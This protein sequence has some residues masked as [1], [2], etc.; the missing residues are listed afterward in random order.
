MTTSSIPFIRP[1]TLG[2]ILDQAFRLYRRNFLIFIFIVAIPYI[3]LT[4]FSSGAMYLYTSSAASIIGNP[5]PGLFPSGGFFL[6]LL[7]LVVVGIL[8]IILIS[9]L[10]AAVLARAVADTYSGQVVE[11]FGSYGKTRPAWL[12]LLGVMLIYL[13]VVFVLGV[14]TMVPCIGWLT[15]PGV[16]F[17]FGIVILPLVAP[18]IILERKGAID[19]FRRAWDLSRTRFW[20]LLGFV[21]VLSLLSQL[22]IVGP[23]YLVNMLMSYVMSSQGD[24]QAQLIWTTVIQSFVQ[25]LGGLLYLPLQLTA[26]TVVYLD[27]R[28]RSEGLDLAMQAAANAGAETNI[29][30]LAETSPQPNPNLISGAEVGQFI[31]LTLAFLA[32]YAI[33]VGVIF[34]IMFAA[35]SAFQ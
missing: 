10:A 34:A 4:L 12:N 5:S 15:G 17:F 14:W 24:L 7:G 25:M 16:L 9:G 22:I 3:P 23:T 18:I 29:I 27:L 30:A 8:S 19:A 33:L 13:V 6:G 21:L 11:V 1:M 26:M 28:V 35:V 20:W 31:L 32:L 2:E